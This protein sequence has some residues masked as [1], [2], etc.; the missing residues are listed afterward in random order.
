MGWY[1][2]QVPTDITGKLSV[3]HSN[4]VGRDD[5]GA[6]W[7]PRVRGSSLQAARPVVVPYRDSPT[8]RAGCRARRPRRAVAAACAG[9]PVHAA[10]SV[11]VPYRATAKFQSVPQGTQALSIAQLLIPI[12]I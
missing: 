3:V 9:K 8:I 1:K 7:Q 12:R 6:P 2:A 10:R 5:L 4:P 11:V